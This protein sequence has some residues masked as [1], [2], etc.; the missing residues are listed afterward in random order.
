MISFGAVVRQKL[1]GSAAALEG[2]QDYKMAHG[3][4][5]EELL[6][7][8]ARSTKRLDILDINITSLPELP[9]GLQELY[10][11]DTLLTSLPKLPSGLQVLY[12]SYTPLSSLPELPSG[13]QELNCSNTQLASLPELPSGLQILRC[14]NTRL[15][16]LPNLPSGL[17]Y[18]DCANTHLTSL[19]ELPSGLQYLDCGNTSLILQREIHESIADYNR[20]WVTWRE[21]KESKERIQAKHRL[22][23]EEIVMEA[24]HPRNVERWVD[25]GVDLA[26]L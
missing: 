1:F 7:R 21:E 9:S 17:E 3:P 12:C 11:Y 23:K 20:R 6:G 14:S 19:P 16:S 25:C 2:T 8:M 10:C 4:D 22:L 15:T 13:L 18:L 26:N 24:W 5:T